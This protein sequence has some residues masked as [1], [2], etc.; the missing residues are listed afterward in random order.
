MGGRRVLLRLGMYRGYLLQ[1]QS[2][3]FLR[4][5]PRVVELCDYYLKAFKRRVQ[6][7]EGGRKREEAV[8]EWRIL[9]GMRQSPLEKRRAA[10][11]L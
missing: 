8:R 1:M 4:V 6:A 9:A 5:P 11:W 10:M 3:S 7:P 2:L